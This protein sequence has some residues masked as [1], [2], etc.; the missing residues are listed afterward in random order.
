MSAINQTSNQLATLVNDSSD[1]E[2]DETTVSVAPIGGDMPKYADEIEPVVPL[3]A[4]AAAT[5]PDVPVK[6][7]CQSNTPSESIAQTVAGAYRNPAI[8]A[9]AQT[10]VSNKLLGEKQ[11]SMELSKVK[12]HSLALLHLL[13]GA[14]RFYNR[15]IRIDAV[16]E[17]HKRMA[18]YKLGIKTHGNRMDVLQQMLNKCLTPEEQYTRLEALEVLNEKE[19]AP[20]KPLYA[21]IDLESFMA[22]P[23]PPPPIAKCTA[24]SSVDEII[25]EFFLQRRKLRG[26]ESEIKRLSGYTPTTDEHFA[27]LANIKAAYKILTDRKNTRNA[28]TLHAEICAALRV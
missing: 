3:K 28:S 19:P 21:G 4:A 26:F 24:S 6:S 12:G 20:Y 11:I 23:P 15:G 1:D 27:K 9:S 13:H 10:G 2:W 8:I 14:A 5:K 25:E 22:E 17:Y 16:A 18:A 7:V